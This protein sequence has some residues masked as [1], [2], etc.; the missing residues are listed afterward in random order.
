MGST[1]FFSIFSFDQRFSDVFG[2]IKREHWEKELKHTT[3]FC[4]MSR[5]SYSK[6][7]LMKSND[8]LINII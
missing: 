6:N 4:V 2:G 5:F 1:L 8:E 7:T 3:V